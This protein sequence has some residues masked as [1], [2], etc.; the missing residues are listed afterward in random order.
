MKIK[1]NNKYV[2]W[3]LTAFAVIAG[4]IFFY[5]LVFH[6]SEL[7]QNIKNLINVIMPV[8]FGL[9]ISYLMTPVLNSIE[10]GVLNP[11]CDKFKIKQSLRRQKWVRAIAVILTS[12]IFFFSIYAL[13]AMLISQIV[14]S[15]KTIVG[16]FDGYIINISNWLNT[17]LED[18]EELRNFI[19]P[20][21]SRLFGEV[22][23]WL[24][25]TATLLDKS[26]ALLKT[27]SLSILGF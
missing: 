13:I 2:K 7:I 5:Y 1:L 10:K 14:P 26:S 15:I 18:N 8:V 23:N 20:Q 6:I 17:L 25:D 19:L 4:S 21:V 9:I 11:L 22:E 3:G 12:L 24:Q 16:N 27:V